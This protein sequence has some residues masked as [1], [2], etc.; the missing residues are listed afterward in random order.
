MKSVVLF[1]HLCL[2]GVWLGCVLTEALFERALLGQGRAQEL[3]LARLHKKV[4]VVVEIP[5]FLGV[6]L[7]GALMAAQVPMTAVLQWKIVFGLIA[8]GANLYC[9]R[10]VWARLALAE[11]GDWD[12]FAAV[13]HRQHQ[14]GAVVLAGLLGAL[15]LGGYLFT[16]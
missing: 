7:T 9:V 3:L 8:I 4:D 15:G 1:I 12:G 5:A 11:A 6:L 13:D 2:V 16:A 10:L 14:W